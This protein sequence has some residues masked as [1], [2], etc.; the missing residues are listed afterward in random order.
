MGV[1][2]G[3]WSDDEVTY[4]FTLR[5]NDKEI[6]EKVSVEEPVVPL[7]EHLE[8]IRQHLTKDSNNQLEVEL[9]NRFRN[10]KPEKSVH[11]YIGYSQDVAGWQVLGIRRRPRINGY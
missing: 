6:A 3:L 5:V 4:Q 11:V 8:M 2:D 7:G 9:T 1:T 10:E